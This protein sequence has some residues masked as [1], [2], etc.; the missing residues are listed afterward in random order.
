[1]KAWEIIKHLEEGGKVIYKHPS[2]G[3]GTDE[4]LLLEVTLTQIIDT[5]ERYCIVVPK[6]KY[7]VEVWHESARVNTEA[8][9]L[10]DW[11]DYAQSEPPHKDKKKFKVTVEEL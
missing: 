10:L 6:V 11:M 4:L 2:C 3:E 8:Y 5:P 9:Q 7:S 1:M